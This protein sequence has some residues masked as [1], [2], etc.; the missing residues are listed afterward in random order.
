MIQRVQSIY[1]ILS[2][3]SLTI[4]LMRYKNIQLQLKM[5]RRLFFIYF[6]IVLAFLLFSV[7]GSQLLGEKEISTKIGWGFVFLIL[8]F[9]FIFLAQIAIKRDKQLLD[10]LNRLR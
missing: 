7:Y 5:I 6:L 9:P 3:I 2:M 8:P 10:S 1:L 4:L